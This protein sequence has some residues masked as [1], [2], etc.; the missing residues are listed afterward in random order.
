[1]KKVFDLVILTVVSF[2]SLV[3]LGLVL[4]IYWLAFEAGWGL[5]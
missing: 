4:K 2:V 3:L 5:L 1:M